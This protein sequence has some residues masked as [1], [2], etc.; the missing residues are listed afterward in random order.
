LFRADLVACTDEPPAE[1]AYGLVAVGEEV[2]GRR[3]Y[4]DAREIRAPEDG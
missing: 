1:I 2:D 4:A 3:F